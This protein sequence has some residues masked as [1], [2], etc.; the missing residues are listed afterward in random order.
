M[1]IQQESFNTAENSNSLIIIIQKYQIYS[2]YSSKSRKFKVFSIYYF[3]FLSSISSDLRMSSNFPFSNPDNLTMNI[4]EDFGYLNKIKELLFRQEKGRIFLISLMFIFNFC[5]F[6]A[7]SHGSIFQTSKSFSVSIN[8]G[9]IK[10]IIGSKVLNV[11]DFF[12]VWK[13][14]KLL[15]DELFQKKNP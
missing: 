1:F 8:S 9:F 5:G 3:N 10:G 7:I 15:L 6:K 13:L 2:F 11:I 12:F 4:K 14:L